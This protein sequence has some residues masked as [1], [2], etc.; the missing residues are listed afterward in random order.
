MPT[1]ERIAKVERVLS[2]RQPD[3][4]VVLEGVTLPHNASAV[5]RTCDAAGVGHLDLV[6]PNPELLHFNDMVTTGAHKWLDIDIH[7]S[8]SDII[9]KLKTMGMTVAATGMGAD[10]V[11]YTSF[12]FTRPTALVF[13]NES[14]GLT[15]EAFA[16]ADTIIRIPML[17]MVQSLN[18][19]VS[20]AVIL[21]E[22]MRQRSEAGFFEDPRL[23]PEE[24]ERLRRKWLRP[25]PPE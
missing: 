4:R 1:E 5:I 11:P 22:A 12:D 14:D 16:M 18:L 19:S 2:A 17:G 6:S 13:G 15:P 3:L 24:Y 23:A 20:V 9:P 25:A 10:A 7:G 21:Y 8:L